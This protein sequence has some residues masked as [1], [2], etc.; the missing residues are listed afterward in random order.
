M[1]SESD[2]A[3][4]GSRTPRATERRDWHT[5]PVYEASALG[6]RNFWYPVT[7]SSQ[8][9]RRPASVQLLG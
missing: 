9:G 1:T 7:W 3:A 5:W 8:V 2:S 4:E 6:L